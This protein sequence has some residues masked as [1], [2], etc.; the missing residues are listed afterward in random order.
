[1]VEPV[2][3][4]RATLYL[5]DCHALRVDLPSVDHVFTDPPYGGEETHQDHLSGV[6]LTDKYPARQQLGFD[7]LSLEQMRF[8]AG[9]WV[10][11]ARRWVVFTCEWKYVHALPHLV[12]MGIWRKPD[13]APQFTGD[14]PGMG[15]E[16]VAICHRDGKKRW[17]GGGRHAV[18]NVGY[19]TDPALFKQRADKHPTQKPVG[20]VKAWVS[21]FTDEG[22]TILDPFMGSGTTGVAAVQMGR[23]FIGIEKDP[24]WFAVACRRIEE[25]Q[26]QG[27]MF[28]E[29]AA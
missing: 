6:N 26:R 1:M 15:W 17:N 19:Q 24:H 21:D 10:M 2:I 7:G 29:A 23:K 28:I 13:S 4:G 12:R 14:R 3:I 5:G 25:A 27:D 9:Q 8:F 20:L 18:W 22:E 11:R 16:A